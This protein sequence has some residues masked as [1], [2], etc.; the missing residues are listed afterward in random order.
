MKFT[1]NPPS[2]PI[3]PGINMAQEWYRFFSRVQNEIGNNQISDLGSA[4][5][6]VFSASDILTNEKVLTQGA[7]LTFT[8]APNTLTLALTASGVT[9][10]S[11]GDASNFV[12]LTVDT[13]GR[14]TAIDEFPAGSAAVS[15][16]TIDFGAFPGSN[17]ASVA[18]ADTAI[19]A[20]SNIRAWFA[21]DATS[22][23]H[24]A[25][26]HRYAPVFIEL[27]ALPT[28]GVGGTIYA[29]SEHKM[30]GQWSVKYSWS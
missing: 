12:A 18:F 21:A 14:V 8:S 11:Y 22:A 29:R 4:P 26:D 25:L 7:G 13:Y 24:T 17:E 16:A 15:S 2:T 5:V 10:G 23:D 19:A 9:P 1:I 6:L 3:A 27:T 28:A 20:G 30:Q